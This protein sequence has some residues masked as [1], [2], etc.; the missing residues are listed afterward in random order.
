RPRASRANR[1]RHHARVDMQTSPVTSQR[2]MLLQRNDLI[3]EAP[4]RTPTLQSRLNAPIAGRDFTAIPGG[5]N[6]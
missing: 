1:R 3:A 5:V 2:N 4:V 6:K